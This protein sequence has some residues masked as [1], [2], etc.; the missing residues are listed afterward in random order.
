M[1]L[2]NKIDSLLQQ[3]AEP[4]DT[5]TKPSPVP[6]FLTEMNEVDFSFPKTQGFCH[7][8]TAT[9]AKMRFKD[10]VIIITGG[11]GNFG[12]SCAMRM[13][14]EGCHIALW[15]IAD[16]TDAVTQITSK[17]RDIQ[18]RAYSVD[19]T[20]EEMVQK[21]TDRVVEDFGTID[22]LFNNAG[23]QGQFQPTHKYPVKD[24]AKVM[25][26]NVVGAFTVLKYVANAMIKCNSNGS[27]VSS[28]SRAGVGCPPNMV[29][30]GAS[31]AALAQMTRIA[32]KDLAPH[33][34]RVNSVSPALVG[35]GFMWKRQIE[36]QA[37]AGTIYNP[38]DPKK[39]AKKFINSPFMKRYGSMD[40]VMGP[41]TFL[42]SDDA[43]YLTGVDIPITGGK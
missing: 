6:Y 7:E 22:Y 35:P 41:V 15:D 40:E 32:S 4:A 1:S 3:T 19:I 42:F 31:K 27:I 28:A 23:Y 38:S 24:F 20:K 10:K 17:Y 34:I 39:T 13:A 5:N 30:Y 2:L 14:S 9:R 26:I 33:N 36:L 12:V 29:A 8:Q 18:C 21:A 37:A 16:C 43:S 25:E 11:A